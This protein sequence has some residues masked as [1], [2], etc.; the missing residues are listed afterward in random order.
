M[1]TLQHSPI[2]E[3]WIHVVKEQQRTIV[4]KL[5]E[6]DGQKFHVDEWTRPGGGYGISCVLEDGNVFE[7]GGVMVSVV[8][9]TMTGAAA[10]AQMRASHASIPEGVEALPYS[11][12]GLSLIMHPKNPLAPTVHMNCRF[13]ET[14]DP[15]TGRVNLC[16][17]GGGADLTPCYVYE[18]DAR[19]FHACLRD[20]CDR[21][22]ETY[23]PRFK[24]WCDQY[25]WNA[26]RNEARGIGGIFFDDLEASS[27]QELDSLFGFARDV[28][29]VFPEA[30]LPIVEKRRHESF[31]EAQKQWQQLRRGRYVEFNLLHD[32]GT[33][34]GL[35]GS[36]P[37]VESILVSMPLTASWKYY[38]EPEAGSREQQLVDV[39]RT[40][41]EWV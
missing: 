2:H 41:K 36:S 31:T 22:N 24:K 6:I 27:E 16:W 4:A 14:F 25:F 40:P 23:Y 32:R 39:L 7:R 17:F 20:V 9:G 38:H 18:E 29:Q 33:K 12:V 21:Y 15:E 5:E 8:H 26:H 35:A 13:L 10:V 34:F 30:Y 11:A 3:K 19:H 28:L 1:A 37:R